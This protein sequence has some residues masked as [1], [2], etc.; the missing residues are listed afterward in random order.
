MIYDDG[1]EMNE[2]MRVS[3]CPRCENEE[4]SEEAEYC[5]ICGLRAYNYCEGEPEY[6]WNGYQT[7][8]HYHRNPSNA[9]YCETCGNPTIFFKEKILRPWKDVNNELEAEDD[10]AF[11]EVVATADDPDDFP[12]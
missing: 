3:T 4:F 8:T 11:A 5:R 7:D 9:R 1:V 6:D 12:F 10:S 2:D